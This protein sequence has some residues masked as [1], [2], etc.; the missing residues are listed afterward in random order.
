M[1]E[2][3]LVRLK[4]AYGVTRPGAAG[5]LVLD[6]LTTG[7][8]GKDMLHETLFRAPRNVAVGTW[9]AIQNLIP[10]AADTV[11]AAIHRRWKRYNLEDRESE[12]L[13]GTVESVNK[14]QQALRD[15]R[16]GAILSS[17]FAESLDGPVDDLGHAVLGAP[18]KVIVPVS[19]N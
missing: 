5:R 16:P 4:P 13:R 9:H 17:I 15:G 8:E 2:K 10:I 7:I 14:I 11:D 1:K 12:S 6:D 3:R 19:S 18:N